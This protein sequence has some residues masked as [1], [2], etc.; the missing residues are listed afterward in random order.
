MPRPKSILWVDDE[1]ESLTSHVLF[2]EE[3]GFAVETTAQ[4]FLGIRIQCAKC[5]NHPFDRWTQ[6]DYYDWADVFARIDYK[7]LENNRPD[8]L[9]KEFGMGGDRGRRRG[10]SWRSGGRRRRRRRGAAGDGRRRRRRQR[11]GGGGG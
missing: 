7:I 11:G 6:T 2:L 1:V 3:Q 4:L 8:G 5:H 9:D 10:G